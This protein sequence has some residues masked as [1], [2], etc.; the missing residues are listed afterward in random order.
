MKPGVM[1][2]Q[3]A[4]ICFDWT[5]ICRMPRY[6]VLLISLFISHYKI[7]KSKKDSAISSSF[8]SWKEFL[9]GFLIKT[10]GKL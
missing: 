3:V 5:V 7:F 9:L 6:T 4:Y 8:F 2:Q 1:T 10:V